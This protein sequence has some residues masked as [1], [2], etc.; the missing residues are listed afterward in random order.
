MGVACRKGEPV[1][2]SGRVGAVEAAKRQDADGHGRDYAEPQQPV[3]HELLARR[4]ELLVCCVPSK[5]ARA[6]RDLDD[7]GHGEQPQ[8][9]RTAFQRRDPPA[10][11]SRPR[12]RSKSAA[13][14]PRSMPPHI[15]TIIA[16][17]ATTITVEP[18]TA[19]LL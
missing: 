11:R 17:I 4:L 14:P 6:T 13:P 16:T 12:T 5:I 15:R 1:P 10:A 7:R 18:L 9:S 2:A 3:R 8:Q 19:H